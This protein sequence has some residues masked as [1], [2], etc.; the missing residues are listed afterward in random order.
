MAD[1]KSRNV[2]LDRIRN[3]GIIAHID[4]TV[5]AYLDGK[6]LFSGTCI[7]GFEELSGT[8]MCIFSVDNTAVEDKCIEFRDIAI[9]GETDES[10][11][12]KSS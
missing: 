7:G 4:G 10:V 6:L 5:C 9:S 1:T 2:P 3:I 11:S 12:K 8:R